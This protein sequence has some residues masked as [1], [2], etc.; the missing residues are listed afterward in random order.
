MQKKTLKLISRE[1]DCR[2]IQE[3]GRVL[4]IDRQNRTLCSCQTRVKKKLALSSKLQKELSIKVEQ[5]KGKNLLLSRGAKKGEL[6]FERFWANAHK[7]ELS[8]R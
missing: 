1:S 7:Q 4:L 6:D 3:V 2:P 8:W 5:S